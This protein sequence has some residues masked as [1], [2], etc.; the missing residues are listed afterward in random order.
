MALVWDAEW[1]HDELNY[2]HAHHT[3][4]FATSL[5]LHDAAMSRA[6]SIACQQVR[7]ET[8]TLDFPRPKSQ[9]AADGDERPSKRQHFDRQAHESDAAVGSNQAPAAAAAEVHDPAPSSQGAPQPAEAVGTAASGLH[10]DAGAPGA[11]QQQQ[12]GKVSS[13]AGHGK[14]PPARQPAEP[15]PGSS[16]AAQKYLTCKPNMDSRGHT[17]YLTFARKVVEGWQAAPGQGWKPGG[18]AARQTSSMHI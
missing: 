10:K 15:Q 17:G 7:E 8:M 1:D 16:K 9:A 6:A 14:Q 11:G 18:V 13:E 2:A 3:T 4:C 5:S 12:A